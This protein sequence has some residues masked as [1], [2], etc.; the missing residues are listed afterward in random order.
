[1]RINFCSKITLN[2]PSRAKIMLHKVV[3]IALHNI[4]A[5]DA[6]FVLLRFTQYKKAEVWY[7]PLFRIKG[8]IFTPN[9][10]D[11]L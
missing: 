9:I 3:I 8:F 1:M 7:P 10:G 2:V 11:V 5:T 4:F 6:T